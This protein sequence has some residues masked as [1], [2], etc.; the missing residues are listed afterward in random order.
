MEQPI[1]FVGIDVDDSAYHV[2][3]RG[4]EGK[5]FEFSC[6]PTAGALAKN[7]KNY[8]DKGYELL[9]NPKCKLLKKKI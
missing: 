5:Y 8:M 1:L 4:I 6:K 7:L 2:A 9:A 3:L